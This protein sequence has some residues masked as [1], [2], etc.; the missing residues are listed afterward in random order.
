M[1]QLTPESFEHIPWQTPWRYVRIGEGTGYERE[2]AAEAGKG[3]PLH[4]ARAIAV[5]VRVDQDDVLFLLPDA[6]KPLAVVHLTYSPT[7][8]NASPRKVPHIV[9][10]SSLDDWLQR[11]Q[12]ADH[13]DYVSG[14]V[15]E[16]DD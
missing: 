16:S 14:D 12:S 13:T 10:Y 4:D 8:G 11:G 3:H 6:P 9:F 15:A 2:L 5:G 1:S 7:S